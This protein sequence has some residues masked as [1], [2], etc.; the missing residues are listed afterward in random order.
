[1][2]KIIITLL[3]LT[4][5]SSVAQVKGNKNI[6]TRSFELKN[7][8]VIQ[9]NFYAKIVIDQS[10]KEGMT[11]TMD[12][13]LFD[14]IDTEVVD[15]KLHLDQLKWVQ[16]SQDVII[17]IG[18]PNL[19]K[20]EKGTHETLR[21]INVDTDKLFVNAHVGKVIVQGKAKQFDI[22]AENGEVDA[23]KLIAQN[24]RV[25]IWGWGKATVHVENELYSTLNDDSRLV[26]L[27]EPKKLKGDTKRYL[28]R[29]KNQEVLNIQWITFKI[30]NNSWNRNH[31][32]VV[33]PKEDGSKFSYGFP[34]MPGKVKKERWSTGTKIYKVS[35]LGLRKLLVT[36]KAEDEGTTVKLFEKS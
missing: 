21:I 2:R 22:G 27:N 36:I 19:K 8:E 16:P 31:F 26:I 17:N 20:V 33:G 12:S 30:K 24:S 29:K 9:I 3:I 34:M 23:S 11:I 32:V 7:V 35:K 15:N 14:K 13:N 25:N 28:A 1:M 4:S 5:I 10:A 6:E 18:A